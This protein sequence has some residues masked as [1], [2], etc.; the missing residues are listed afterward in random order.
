MKSQGWTKCF[1]QLAVCLAVLVAS[2]CVAYSADAKFGKLNLEGVY[3]NSTRIKA[4]LDEIK[5]IQAE[6]EA[7][8]ASLKTEVDKIEEKLG[9]EESKLKKEEKE[10]LTKDLE[11]KNQAIEQ[12]QQSA[13]AKVIFK[14]RSVQNVIGLQIRSIL[15]KIAKEDGLTAVLAQQAVLY[16]ADV[17]D[18]TDRVTKELDAM[19]AAES[20]KP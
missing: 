1:A 16:S 6:A 4:A 11:L 10:K 2:A 19:P 8:M 5:N 12:E 15:E 18:L 13:R 20:V 9:V 3:S 17:V 7:K 14:Q